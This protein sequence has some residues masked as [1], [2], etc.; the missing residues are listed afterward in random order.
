[1]LIQS[2]GPLPDKPSQ[3]PATTPVTIADAPG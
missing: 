3:S 1:M 2:L